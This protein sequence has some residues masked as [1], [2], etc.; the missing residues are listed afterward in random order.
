MKE[1]FRVFD[2]DGDGFIGLDELAKVMAMLGEDLSPAELRSML[3][4]ADTK[5]DGKIDY[6]EFRQL[7]SIIRQ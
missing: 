2:L 4:E 1:T 6:E 7:F 3:E 5:K